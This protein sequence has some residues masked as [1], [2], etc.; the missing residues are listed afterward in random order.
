MKMKR[1]ICLLLSIVMVLSVLVGCQ[2]ELAVS[3]DPS[4]DSTLAPTQDLTTVP[5]TPTETTAPQA[6]AM[7]LSA[8]KD[9][10]L[11]V[12]LQAR[13]DEILNTETEIV[14]SDTFIPGMKISADLA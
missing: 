14:H 9:A 8:E 2:A 1:T 13:I 10:K 7:V 12:D 5:E 4:S 3:T 11:R 6:S